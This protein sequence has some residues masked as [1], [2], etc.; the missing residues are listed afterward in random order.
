MALVRKLE[1]L[2]KSKRR[3]AARAITDL[4]TAIAG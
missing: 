2:P 1:R 3:D 4:I